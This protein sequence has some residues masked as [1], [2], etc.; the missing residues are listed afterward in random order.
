MT[1]QRDAMRIS[2]K[3]KIAIVIGATVAITAIVAFRS[4][5]A[6]VRRQ[7][8]PSAMGA[9]APSYPPAMG[10][11][12]IVV[13][14]RAPTPTQLRA[15]VVDNPDL[16]AAVLRVNTTSSTE[17]K[18]A[19]WSVLNACIN[20][21]RK[22]QRARNAAETAAASELGTRCATLQAGGMRLNEAASKANEFQRMADADNSPLG[23][24]LALSQ[25]SLRGSINWYE[26]E[27][28]LV[29]AALQSGDPILV[30]EASRALSAR[31]D[32]GSSPDAALRAAA[33]TFAV[34]LYE[35]DRPGT[36]FDRLVDCAI[37]GRCA[38]ASPAKKIDERFAPTEQRE[39]RRLLEHYR[40]A[41]HR[42]VTA[43]ELLALR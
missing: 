9:R 27:T 28:T 7:E 2:N 34:D 15:Q 26:R 30:R 8:Q 43:D 23:E 33:F 6:S 31:I 18:M 21:T 14:A 35:Q 11:P 22:N 17:Q 42:G 36:Q 40:L 13:T 29:T 5:S 10:G 3:T 19:A 24:L 1:T 4:D 37:G 41:L 20:I 32:D 39:V 25:R 12:D 16:Y 38:V